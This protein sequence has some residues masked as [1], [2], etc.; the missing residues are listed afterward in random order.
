M[1][2]ISL[3]LSGIKIDLSFLLPNH[4]TPSPEFPQPFLFSEE[5]ITAALRR[6]GPDSLGAKTVNL[7]FNNNNNNLFDEPQSCVVKSF[8]DEEGAV[9]NGCGNRLYGEL[10]FIGATLQLRGVNPVIQPLTDSYHNVLVYN[11]EIFGGVHLSS[12]SNDTEILMQSLAN[13]CSCTSHEGRCRSSTCSEGSRE[14][15]PELLSRIRGPWALIYWQ[16]TLRDIDDEKAKVELN[17]WEEL[18]CGVYSISV[19]PLETDGHLIGKVKKHGWTDTELKEL[20]KWKRTTVEPKPENLSL[21]FKKALTIEQG[22]VQ[23][24][25]LATSHKVL[26]ALKESVKRRTTLNRIYQVLLGNHKREKSAPIAVLFSGGL[27]SMII[28][29]LLHQCVDSEYEIDLLNISF[30]GESA[31]DRITA[32]AGLNELRKIASS[33]RWNLI[34]IDA[35]L[36][37]LTSETQ[38]VM[39]LINPAKTYM[40]LNIG[41]ALWLAARGD[42][43][44]YEG[45]HCERVT[46]KSESRIL[47][48]GSG[49]DEQC[50]GYGR[51]KTKFRNKSWLG[52]DE[53]MK[54]DMQRIWKRN[55][56]RDDRI[57][58]D[59]GK[60]ARFP[61]LD[62]DVIKTLLDIPLWEIADLDQPSGVGDKKILR[63]VARLLGLNEAAIL[64]KRAIQ[65]GSRIA[66]ES[67]RKNFGSNRA[68]N[69]AS[70]GSVVIYGSSD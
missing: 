52:L 70:A 18:A 10:R 69:Q 27:D 47:L 32:R 16:V 54:L 65:F 67:N 61:F 6:R 64:P 34:E 26:K 56:G 5:E 13:C 25:P 50:A 14:S 28:A 40:D 1:C 30:D 43:W 53:E 20:T 2:G 58:A 33:R 12:D 48:V 63:E 42:G 7:Y 4:T 9:E 59:N 60:E 45:T 17:F 24:T 21:D 44:L 41:I 22:I 55:L 36:T 39:S 19:S 38:H 15:V 23:S 51:H 8:S 35:Y 57:I 37:K 29:A 49:A 3:I 46:Y 62:E 31:P 66:R 11:G 68:A